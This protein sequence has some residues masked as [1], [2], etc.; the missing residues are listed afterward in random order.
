MINI[1]T[2]AIYHSLALFLIF[3]LPFLSFTQE[4]NKA[5]AIEANNLVMSQNSSE[6]DF[7]NPQRRANSNKNYRRSK[8]AQYRKGR[9]NQYRK[10][11]QKPNKRVSKAK[12]AR[13][14]KASTKAAAAKSSGGVG[15]FLASNWYWIAAGAVAGGAAAAGGG[16]GGGGSGG[17]SSA[18]TTNTETGGDTTTAGDSGST[19]VFG[20]DL[21]N[22]FSCASTAEADAFKTDEYNNSDFL[23]DINAAEAY[24]TLEKNGL[25][26]GGD[27]VQI[28]INDEPIFVTHDELSSKISSTYSTDDPSHGTHVAA[29]AAGAKDDSGMHGV[30]F[31]STLIS[32]ELGEIAA[33]ASNTIASQTK[34]V[35]ASWGFP[36]QSSSDPTRSQE[37]WITI[38]NLFNGNYYNDFKALIN[39]EDILMVVA[40]GNDGDS[41]ASVTNPTPMAFFAANSDMQGK[42]IAVVAVDENGKRAGFSNPAGEAASRSISALGVDV[43]SAFGTSFDVGF[44]SMPFTIGSG[45][46]NRQESLDFALSFDSTN[47]LNKVRDVSGNVITQ[48]LTYCESGCSTIEAFIFFNNATNDADK[49]FF[50]VHGDSRSNLEILD[51]DLVA[52]ADQS[53]F[54]AMWDA[55]PI[56]KDNT[57]QYYF[58]DGT[59]MAAPVVTG[60]AAVLEGAW[61]FLDAKEIADILLVTAKPTYVTDSGGVTNDVTQ[62]A[63]SDRNCGNDSSVLGVTRQLSCV[64]G[65]GTLDLAKAVSAQGEHSITAATS[66]E[67]I[68]SASIYKVSESFMNDNTLS[69]SSN[70][71]SD[72]VFFDVFGRNYKA[73]FGNNMSS[74]FQNST[75]IFANNNIMKAQDYKTSNFADANHSL[76]MNLKQKDNVKYADPSDPSFKLA[77]NGYNIA[78][79]FNLGLAVNDVQKVIEDD[80]NFNITQMLKSSFLA[81]EIADGYLHK[82]NNINYQENDHIQNTSFRFGSRINDYLSTNIAIAEFKNPHFHNVKQSKSKARR[83]QFVMHDKAKKSALSLSLTNLNEE[84]GNFLGSQTSGAFNLGNSNDTNYAKMSYFGDIGEKTSFLLSYIDGT[85]KLQ[86]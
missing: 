73:N 68:H 75:S 74:N 76:S 32:T 24:A 30:A 15:K 7:T 14:S 19:S 46:G 55:S 34:I 79:I 6:S 53:K 77:F 39:N 44:I 29:I 20:T 11:Y 2:K 67:N 22:N 84:N 26:V 82:F 61:G 57:N 23:S 8:N 80:Q 54:E 16:G 69:L 27:G 59:S 64:Y 40:A 83:M 85:S 62:A 35:N 38:L 56:N 65:Q 5:Y 33:L 13:Y 63:A 86:G 45:V 58:S 71:F 1:I 49:R 28:M 42:M 41:F 66:A 10:K 31:N 70:A 9:N 4:F 43:L 50:L 52:A 60:A 3:T 18:S 51:Y 81:E 37:E 25:A 72:A 47:N 21:C 17:G 48:T 78:K 36:Y 12:K